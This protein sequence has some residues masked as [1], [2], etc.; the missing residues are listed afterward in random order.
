M[1]VWSYLP[2]SSE[3]AL[4]DARREWRYEQPEEPVLDP[5][6]ETVVYDPDPEAAE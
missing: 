5:D 4:R 1:S 2:Y 3:D 6:Y